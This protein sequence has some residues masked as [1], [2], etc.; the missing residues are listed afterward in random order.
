MPKVYARSPL[1]FRGEGFFVD[2]QKVSHTT[3]APNAVTIRNL[4]KLMK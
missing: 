3:N 1:R 2:L 4:S